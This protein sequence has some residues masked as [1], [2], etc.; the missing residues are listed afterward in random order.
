MNKSIRYL[1]S[2]VLILALFQP[3]FPAWADV[4]REDQR[5]AEFLYNFLKFVEWPA[6]VLPEASSPLCLCMTGDGSVEKNLETLNSRT[7]RGRAIIVKPLTTPGQLEKCHVLFIASSEK[8][9]FRNLLGQIRN[10]TILT[11]SDL[12]RFAPQGGMIGLFNQKGR[13]NFEINLDVVHQSQL[14]FS[15]QLLRLA[16]I[17]HND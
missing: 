6:K 10:H 12:P 7:V 15:A 14:R 1:S 5:K 16:R 2:L 4:T 9:N 3:L 8:K 11:V 17:V 13:I